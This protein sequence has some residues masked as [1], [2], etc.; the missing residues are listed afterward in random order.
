M[1]PHEPVTPDE[2]IEDV[3]QVSNLGATIVHLHTCDPVTGKPVYE[4]EIYGEI[5]RGTLNCK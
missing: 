3:L 2:I 5:I 4:K 1:T